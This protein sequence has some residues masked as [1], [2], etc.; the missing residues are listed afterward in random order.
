VSSDYARHSRAATEIA[1]EYL[2]AERVVGAMLDRFAAT[3]TA[4]AAGR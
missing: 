2:D 4:E 3:Q 1:R